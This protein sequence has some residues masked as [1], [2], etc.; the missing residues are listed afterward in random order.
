MYIGGSQTPATSADISSRSAGPP[1]LGP[2]QPPCGLPEGVLAHLEQ[3]STVLGGMRQHT[4][5]AAPAGNAEQETEPA[6]DPAVVDRQLKSQR[7]LLKKFQEFEA[8]LPAGESRERDA[9]RDWQL[10]FQLLNLRDA[11]HQRV[12]GRY[13]VEAATVLHGLANMTFNALDGRL[14]AVHSAAEKCMPA[15]AAVRQRKPGTMRPPAAASLRQQA[16]SHAIKDFFTGVNWQALVRCTQGSLL[17]LAGLVS[18]ARDHYPGLGQAIDGVWDM[19]NDLVRTL[20][21]P[22]G[23]AADCQ[24][25]LLQCKAMMLHAQAF[26]AAL[27]RPP[28]LRRPIWLYRHMR[29]PAGDAAAL[30]RRASADLAWLRKYQECLACC[31]CAGQPDEAFRALSLEGLSQVKRV[32]GDLQ[33]TLEVLLGCSTGAELAE[34]AVP[35]RLLDAVKSGLAELEGRSSIIACIPDGPAGQ[36]I[37]RMVSASVIQ[38]TM[39]DA[40][41]CFGTAPV[42]RRA[43]AEFEAFVAQLPSQPA[44]P[45]QGPASSSGDVPDDVPVS[46]P[47]AGVAAAASASGPPASRPRASASARG[48]ASDAS[49]P[50]AVE[51]PGTSGYIRL[52]LEQAARQQSGAPA[53]RAGLARALDGLDTEAFSRLEDA[54]QAGLLRSM[55]RLVNLCS[56]AAEPVYYQHLNRLLAL[57]LACRDP[58]ARADFLRCLLVQFQGESMVQK[59]GNE[60]LF[61][62]FACLGGASRLLSAMR[63]LQLEGHEADRLLAAEAIRTLAGKLA[64]GGEGLAD[65]EFLQSLQHYRDLHSAGWSYADPETRRQFVEDRVSTLANTFFQLAAF[66]DDP[67]LACETAG[68]AQSFAR[69][70]GLQGSR[71]WPT[72]AEAWR[73]LAVEQLIHAGGHPCRVKADTAEVR[74]DAHSLDPSLTACLVASLVDQKHADGSPRWKSIRIVVG[75]A[76]AGRPADRSQRAALSAVLAGLP[77]PWVAHQPDKV[78]VLIHHGGNAKGQRPH[79]GFD[80]PPAGIA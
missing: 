23:S 7:F 54:E 25:L 16:V 14:T 64:A 21:A 30:G 10:R 42:L 3:L 2:N 15:V 79:G 17:V 67:G 72:S 24:Q 61:K 9:A 52:A 18:A 39:Q 5:G 66:A 34:P 44:S 55:A 63:L 71:A 38:S 41:K 62:R 29:P 43:A 48:T 78:T 35:R 32:A 13:A 1:L 73:Q 45:S 22:H 49:R 27:G 47:D 26:Q 6:A 69:M 11:A 8:A 80:A 77:P 70:H 58:V 28:A 4:H 20:A 37:S 59:D 76:H 12:A 53:W 33:T 50:D 65:G 57:G 56:G 75:Q 74:L 46:S 60:E 36:P 40:L 68:I 51:R 31:L 19:A